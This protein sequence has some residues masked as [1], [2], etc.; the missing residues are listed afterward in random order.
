MKIRTIMALAITMACAPATAQTVATAA[1]L[2]PMAGAFRE[3]WRQTD[4]PIRM[5]IPLHGGVLE[6][7]MPHGFLPALRVEADGQF[8]M[9][10]IPDGEAWPAFSRAVLVQSSA[11]LGA[12]PFP[13]AQI[14]EEIFKPKSCSG[15]ALWEPLGEAD[16]GSNEQAF[17]ASTGC[18]ALGDEPDRGQQT[19]LALLRGSQDAVALSFAVRSPAFSAD[20]PPI[21]S[22]GARNH[23]AQFGQI[24]LCRSAEQPGCREIWAREMIRRNMRQ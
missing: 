22:A 15:P 7:A 3:G 1:D 5:T 16:T 21:E 2:A 4:Q 19:F 23:L 20:A 18:T 14:A 10:F 9:A 12:A 6:F 24:I 17:F 13:T 11:G 8:F